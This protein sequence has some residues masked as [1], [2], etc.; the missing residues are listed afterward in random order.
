[1]NESELIAALVAVVKSRVA[2][3]LASRPLAERV[4]VDR[5]E[6]LA[7]TVARAAAEAVLQAWTHDVEQLALE[8]GL[9]CAACGKR[10]KCKRRAG[11]PMHVHLL[12]LTVEL[13]KL[14]LE[15]GCGAPGLSITKLLTGL[16][17][18]EA[19]AELELMAA[20]CAAEHS[21][22]KASG[23]LEAHHGEPVERTAVRR[24]AL[25]VESE[26][27]QSAEAQRVQV[28]RTVEQ[29][30]RVV[31]AAQLMVQ[32]DGGIVRTG[33]L[34][35]CKPGD[36]GYRKK[37]PKTDKPRRRRETQYREIITLD[38]RAPGQTSASALDVVV[39]VV[40]PEGE[41]ARRMLAL[42][43]REGLGH[44]TEVFG[45]GD[46]GSSLAESFDEAFVG[47][48]ATYSADWKHTSDYVDK[49]AAVLEEHP[50]GTTRW[51]KQ[52]KSALWNRQRKR[53]DAL[54]QYAREHRVADLPAHLEKCP[55]AAL[56]T[57]VNNNWERLHAKSFKERGLDFVS[58][59]GES[60]VRDRT[61]A[62]YA[63]PG[64]W[65]QE[66]LEGK[67]IL[68]SII[69]DGR[70]PAFRQH[71]LDTRRERFDHELHTRL[72]AAIEQGR[73]RAVCLSNAGAPLPASEVHEAAA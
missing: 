42:A 6:A 49:A 25:E 29:E 34:L 39:P 10:R 73:L 65:R 4:S 11:E 22:G 24:M 27:K 9:A 53:A 7:R 58:A 28:L 32:G 30:Q 5:A 23:E 68:R 45:L 31:G 44:N 54:L 48:D 60:Q 8:V 15:C 46:M 43:A 66:N 17:S 33:T 52:M 21:Y 51:A 57:Y 35:P 3:Q 62:R 26:A 40:A 12:G 14:Y 37:T 71:Y 18:G 13:P 63:V 59:R 70:W 41:R 2:S 16:S 36:A 50:S 69:A 67:A 61:K 38:V 64:A 47:H 19:S 72:H 20:Y 56:R 55:V 1:M